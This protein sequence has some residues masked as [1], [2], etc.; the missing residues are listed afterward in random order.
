MNTKE[1][2]KKRFIDLYSK[3]SYDKITVRSLCESVPIARTTFYAYYQ[4]IDE[5][6]TEIENCTVSGIR[7]ACESIYSGDTEKQFMSAMEYMNSNK[8]VFY[9]F[10]VA[11]PDIRF[12]EKFKAE[13]AAHFEENFKLDQCGKNYELKLELFASA[14]VS[15]YTYYLKHPDETDIENIGEKLALLKNSIDLFL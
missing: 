8:N 1:L 15:Y 7:S 4:N 11:Q 6:K 9:A 14:V 3:T 10:L 12:I 2:I 5:V 13:I